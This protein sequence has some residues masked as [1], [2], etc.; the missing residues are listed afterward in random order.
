[1]KRPAAR[2]ASQGSWRQRMRH[3]AETGS[4]S[5]NRDRQQVQ[6]ETKSDSSIRDRQRSQRRGPVNVMDGGIP[7]GID[8][9]EAT[10]A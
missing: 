7:R 3:P 9:G 1:M 5:S 10:A 2:P 8:V 6:L 4:T